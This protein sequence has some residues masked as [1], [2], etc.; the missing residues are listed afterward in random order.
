M[1]RFLIKSSVV[2]ALGGL[3]FGFD[4]A[5]ISGAVSDLVSGFNLTAESL[6][7]TVSSALL[8]TIIGALFAS[9]PG[10]RYGRRDSLRG[11]AVLYF[12]SSVG[13]AVAWDWHSLLLFRV[14][15]G[16]AIGGSSVLGPMYIAEIAPARRRGWLVGFFQFN[17]V[18]GILLAYFS[19]YVIN[20]FNLGISEWRWM[21]GVAAGPAAF[22]FMMLFAIPRSPRWLIK[23]GRIDDARNVLR[24]TEGDCE[25]EVSSIIYSIKI[26]RES[27]GESLFVRQ[28]R[29]PIFLAISVGAFNQLSGINAVL[30]Y[31]NYIF[32]SA[33]F[34]AVSSSQQAILVGATLLVFTVVGMVTID[35]LGR[36]LLLLVGSLGTA[37]CLFGVALIFS[38]HKH[39]GLLLWL[40]MAFIAFFAVSQGAVIW[41]YIS[42]VFPNSVRAKGQSLGS[43]SHW[44][45][46]ALISMLFP[47]VAAVSGAYPFY[48]FGAMMIMQFLVVLYLYPE[49][50]GVPLEELQ[51]QLVQ[52]RATPEHVR[53]FK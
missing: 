21:L 30:Y 46:N 5:V 48:F 16:L 8:G 51:R 24:L 20:S 3:L 1:N 36:R 22:F 40:L 39:E 53:D 6:G 14:V 15:G 41:V 37:A 10:E 28:H 17:I 42:E 27:G 49:T 2:A 44:T 34:G 11:L 29:L 19:N 25:D 52:R 9:I 18:L 13:C 33:G 12:V 43:F 32:A 31:L 50:K 45:M 26:E 4:T 23:Q 7:F 47:M 38:V 35:L